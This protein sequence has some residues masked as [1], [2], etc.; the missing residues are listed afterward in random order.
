[1]KRLAHLI[2][3]ISILAFVT[4]GCAPAPTS[5]ASTTSAPATVP[6]ASSTPEALSSP[7]S[8]SAPEVVESPTAQTYHPD[9]SIIQP[10]AAAVPLVL[11]PI[12]EVQPIPNG[13]VYL[14]D[15]ATL[16]LGF[17]M[18]GGGAVGSLLYNGRE[19]VDHTDYGRYFQLSLY[20]GGDH[21]GPRGDDPYGD[22][23][24]N[25]LQAGSS[26]GGG[27]LIGAK[28]LE[29]RR[30]D[31]MVYIKA[32]GKEWGPDDEDSDII[33]ETWA[34][35]RD[36]YFE[37]HSRATHTGNDTHTLADQE[38]PAAYYEWALT[39]MYGYFGNKP[40]TGDT[41][42]ELNHVAREGEYAGMASCPRVNPTE[43]WAAF[44]DSDLS[45]L[46][47]LVPPQ[48]YLQPRWN[49]CLLYAQPPV[50]YIS[51]MASFDVP[52]GAVRDITYY[53]IPGPVETGRAIVY[54][55]LPHTTWN[56]DLN[57]FEGWQGASA[58]DSVENGILTVNLTPGSLLTSQPELNVS[59]AISP[60]M[61]L[62]ARAHEEIHLCLHFITTADAQW[63]VAK[64][65]CIPLAAG[66]MQT[67][68]FD[69]SQNA[70]WMDGV[71]TQLAL[72][73][74]NPAHIEIDFMKVEAQGLAWEFETGGVLEGWVAWNHLTPLE[75]SAGILSAEGTGDDPYIGSPV[76]T[77]DAAQ[78]PIIEI[79][80]AVT[81]GS[82]AQVFFLTA[83]S[84]IYD[85]AKALS[86][87]IIADGKFHTYRL[88]MAKVG[89]WKGT[90]TQI[91][92]DP[93]DA[94]TS[95]GVEYIRI[96]PK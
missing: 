89:T 30:A 58:Q 36:G 94:I 54:D 53:M 69:L 72:T 83:T 68:S 95:V 79:R 34:F 73:A 28:T 23:G 70:A 2:K 76:F 25:P 66:N 7:T 15:K 17:N 63:D 56:F 92:L 13:F 48:A 21:Y 5:P 18:D 33:Y 88:D 85:E 55:L 27:L 38:F 71:V 87:P 90:I 42:E 86:F 49:I 6:A 84:T 50:G 67:G 41:I 4:G 29:F 32:L 61:T 39:H 65:S 59:G 44:G 12:G 81:G 60:M 82:N 1:M 75:T 80:M 51:P 96:T 10:P 26:A 20:D 45:G 43:N 35:Q 52:A 77:L 74:S 57:S 11:A 16:A 91:R 40:F 24:W 64:S 3:L 62:S 46:I 47:L 9:Y 8:S 37:I 31:G 22:W 19:L 78:F 93:A 14:G